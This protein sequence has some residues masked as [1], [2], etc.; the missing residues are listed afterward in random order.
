[1]QFFLKYP[2]I[3]VIVS[4]FFWGSY[5]IPLRY[6]NE[7]GKNSVWPIIISFLVLSIIL[8]LPLIKSIKQF[9]KNK[10]IYFFLGNLFS[11]LGIAL[12]SDSLLRGEIAKVVI[13]FY[14]CPVWGTILAKIILN[15]KF[16]FQ[17]YMS[18][19]L[20]IIG[21]EIILKF[22]EGIFFPSTIVEYMALT[23]G[24]SWALGMTF[25]HLSK[26]SKGL[27]KTAFTSIFIPI[28]F[29]LLAFIPGGRDIEIININFSSN[30]FIL[31][32]FL[33]AI[34]WLLP[35]ILLTYVSVEVLD[36]GRI[37]ILLMFEVIIGITT[38]ALLTTEIIG[39]REVIGGLVII[40][41]ACIDLIKIRT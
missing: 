37:N 5:W 7:V 21:L 33:F 8:V 26:T 16:N 12:Y 23:A 2:N 32:I 11:A 34:I 30:V 6:I 31:L 36:P 13:L 35:S 27:E 17:R 29:L 14:L 41:A 4:S 28:F 18:L 19:F 15:I 24:F 38:A 40:S 10:D 9:L 20:G 1:M 25:F 3:A 39:I 22:D